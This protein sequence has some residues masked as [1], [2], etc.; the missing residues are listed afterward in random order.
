MLC[1]HRPRNVSTSPIPGIASLGIQV[2]ELNHMENNNP[3]VG[4]GVIPL[5][6]TIKL[7]L[8]HSR[9]LGKGY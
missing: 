5:L 4:N 3:A 7:D 1:M 6:A 8:L 2:R 9:E